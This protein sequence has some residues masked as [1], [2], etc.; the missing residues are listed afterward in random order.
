MT[1]GHAGAEVDDDDGVTAFGRGVGDVVEAGGALAQ[2]E[3][4]VVEVLRT[5]VWVQ[6]RERG[7]LRS[8]QGQP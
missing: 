5:L 3:A 1:P 2:V 7:N 4:N 8:Q 6:L